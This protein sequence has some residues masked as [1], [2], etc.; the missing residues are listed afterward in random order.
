MTRPKETQA[1]LTKE[2]LP[3]RPSE[4]ICKY[5]LKF[6]FEYP[7]N[8]D[9]YSVNIPSTIFSAHLATIYDALTRIH[10]NSN[11]VSVDL[12]QELNN[13]PAYSSYIDLLGLLIPY[14][15]LEDAFRRV[16]DYSARMEAAKKT[17][18]LQTLISSN[19]STDQEKNEKLED[20]RKAITAINPKPLLRPVSMADKKERQ[21]L[22]TDE[23]GT[24]TLALGNVYQVAGLPKSG[25]SKMVEVLTA[26]CLGCREWG[27]TAT[28]QAKV[29]VFDTEMDEVDDTDAMARINHLLELD[30]ES[31]NW[32][33]FRYYNIVEV[34]AEEEDPLKVIETQIQNDRPDLVIIDGLNDLLEDPN[35]LS[36]SKNIVKRL[37]RFAKTSGGIGH[38]VCI[39]WL[40]HLN[41]SE[42]AKGKKAGGHSGSQSTMKVS[43]GWIV[44]M[45]E[46]SGI[47]TASNSVHR[48]KPVAPIYIKF[49]QSGNLYNARRE[50]DG[51]TEHEEQILEEKRSTVA[52]LRK[53]A[54]RASYAK[55]YY[56][57][58][59]HLD[60]WDGNPVS[61]EA[62]IKAICQKF[63]KPNQNANRDFKS[64][65]N[66]GILKQNEINPMFFDL[67]E[68]YNQS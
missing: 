26:S 52:L 33:K 64:W 20:I 5:C 41:Q 23:N 31:D 19:F 3:E 38:P 21:Y 12:L 67:L 60:L 54:Q 49:D 62:I 68:P 6:L 65:L 1:V 25:K 29:C 55:R 28:R 4:E 44:E 58:A 24:G 11:N 9:K 13:T 50:H 8:L 47:I 10:R 18:E 2:Y 22:L 39:L 36:T 56:E 17:H 63:D 59:K 46:D 35:D 34:I 27:L 32:D 30:K 43:G 42:G 57:T 61:K 45:D 16:L 48:H 37:N 66:A 51:I 53:E 40:L 15:D 14:Q 7:V